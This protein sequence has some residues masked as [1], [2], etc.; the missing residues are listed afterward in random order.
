M[1]T[2]HDLDRVFWRLIRARAK[3]ICAYCGKTYSNRSL[4]QCSHFHSRRLH[5]VRFDPENC[6]CMC[7]QC[8]H[9]LDTHPCIYEGWKRLQLGEERFEALRLRSLLVVK[10]D[11][12]KIGESIAALA[13]EWGIAYEL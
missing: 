7:F 2:L 8:H 4:L 11:V 12:Q 5:S 1:T 9:V 13:A 6:E 3:W 10:P